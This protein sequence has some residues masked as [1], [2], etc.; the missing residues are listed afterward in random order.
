MTGYIARLLVSTACCSHLYVGC[1]R[2]E[3]SANRDVICG[4]QLDLA[5]ALGRARDRDIVTGINADRTVGGRY[6]AVNCA[7]GSTCHHDASFAVDV[8]GLRVAAACCSHLHIRV[9]RSQRTNTGRWITYANV[10]CRCQLQLVTRG[11][12]T[13]DGDVFASPQSDRSA[14]ARHRAVNRD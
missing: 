14:S 8:A 6:V 3:V 4:G 10:T 11:D 7:A 5:F 13:V 1:R 2:S 12:C 9:S